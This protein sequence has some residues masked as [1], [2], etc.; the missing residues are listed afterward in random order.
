MT[1]VNG[2]KRKPA[3]SV[4]QMDPELDCDRDWLS[5]PTMQQLASGCQWL[6]SC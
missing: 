6:Q 3:T 2:V 4:P 5:Q 1:I